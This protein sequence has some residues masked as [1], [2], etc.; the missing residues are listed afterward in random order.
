MPVTSIDQLSRQSPLFEGLSKRERKAV[1]RLLT[2]VTVPR[3]AVLTQEGERGRE[4]MVIVSGTARVER[5]GTPIAKLG[6]GE[7]FGELSLLT[8]ARRMAMVTAETDMVVAALSRQE[9]ASLLD[10]SPDVAQKILVG[11]LQRLQ[12][13]A[14]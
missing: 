12:Q 10:A 1:V 9:F 6:P 8:G 14:A 4:A 2:T 13:N 11:A 5:D 7:L 3:G